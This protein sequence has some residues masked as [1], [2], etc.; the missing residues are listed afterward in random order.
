[1]WS[2][3]HANGKNNARI[4]TSKYSQ[5]NRTREFHMCMQHKG[6]IVR[7]HQDTMLALLLFSSLTKQVSR[8]AIVHCKYLKGHIC[9]C[10]GKYG[11]YLLHADCLTFASPYFVENQC[12]YALLQLTFRFGPLSALWKFQVSWHREYVSSHTIDHHQAR[13]QVRY[14]ASYTTCSHREFFGKYTWSKVLHVA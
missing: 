14:C 3:R 10:C 4:N 11:L 6:F 13:C 1:M 9:L 12:G 7:P 5:C 2:P 8:L